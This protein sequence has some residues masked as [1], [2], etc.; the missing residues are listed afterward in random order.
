MDE[1]LGYEK[2]EHSDNDDYRNRN[3]TIN[4]VQNI[5]YLLE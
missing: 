4:V 3:Y 1:H 2:S 5:H